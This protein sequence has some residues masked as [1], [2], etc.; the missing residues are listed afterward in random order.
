[1]AGLQSGVSRFVF[2]SAAVV[3]VAADRRRVRSE[4]AGERQ[5]PNVVQASAS[6]AESR[7]SDSE[8]VK[9]ACRSQNDWHAFFFKT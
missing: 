5:T 2:A 7:K 9:K 3:A 8:E 1:V 6:A 4:F